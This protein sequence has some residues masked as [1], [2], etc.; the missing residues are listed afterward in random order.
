MAI[1][2]VSEE[3]DAKIL[4]EVQDRFDVNVTELPDEIDLSS[5]SKFHFTY[6]LNELKYS[7]MF[8]LRY[9][10]YDKY[11][12]FILYLRVS[13]SKSGEIFLNV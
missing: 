10:S 9:S 4:N 8:K 3:A 11:D 2:F 6:Y 1:T 5:Y 12:S 7:M 13:N